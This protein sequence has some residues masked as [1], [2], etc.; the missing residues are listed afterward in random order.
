MSHDNSMQ[1]PAA[2]P[3]SPNGLAEPAPKERDAID[4]VAAA[5]DAAM[6]DTAVYTCDE[7]AK[8]ILV[9]LEAAGYRISRQRPTSYDFQGRR[10]I[11]WSEVELALAAIDVIAV[12]VEMIGRCAV[13]NIHEE[14]LDGVFD[15]L[16]ADLEDN[17][18]NLQR[19][20][21]LTDVQ[22]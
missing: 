1:E 12:K 13:D 14:R 18:G 20:L 9:A 3:A 15:S 4:V 17:V 16:R 22:P 21:G 2:Q 19:L 5:Y 6:S 10:V 11:E 7:A 8:H